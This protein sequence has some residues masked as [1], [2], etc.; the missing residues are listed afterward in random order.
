MPD[1]QEG[2][3]G[4][5][6]RKRISRAC[7]SCYSLRTK[8]NGE[9][10][11]QQCVKTSIPCTF[12]RAR[13][14]RGKAA[15]KEQDGHREPEPL[16]ARPPPVHAYRAGPSLQQHQHQQQQQQGFKQEQGPGI[17]P[18]FP[19]FNDGRT[20]TSDNGM[21][22]PSLQ[23]DQLDTLLSQSP[24]IP[25]DGLL[26][27]P[28]PPRE[29]S[30]MPP[31]NTSSFL[32]PT[33]T[34]MYA[35]E[36]LPSPM[37]GLSMFSQLAGTAAQ[38]NYM[39]NPQSHHADPLEYRRPGSVMGHRGGLPSMTGESPA[40]FKSASPQVH[41]PMHDRYR[42]TYHP[43]GSLPEG[44]R[45]PIFVAHLRALSFLPLHVISHLA[46]TYFDNSPY[47]LGYTLRQRDF[48]HPTTPRVTSPALVFA[49]L[50]VSAHT[51]ENAFFGQTPVMRAKIVQRLFELSVAA[52]RPLQHDEV[53]GGGLDDV[54]TYTQLGTIIM[55]SEFKGVSLRW[56]Y[57]A[58]TLAKELHLNREWT[59]HT[60]I[61]E[62]TREERRR[63]WWL[64]FMI[65]RHLCL[66]Y[67][68]PMVLMDVE[69]TN[70]L[71]PMDEQLW[72]SHEDIDG[73]GELNMSGD[74]QTPD[75]YL[76]QH[77]QQQH[78][79]GQFLKMLYEER[80]RGPRVFQ[81]Q[82]PGIFGFFLPLMSILGE[83]CTIFH[84]KHH[85]LLRFDDLAPQKARVREHLDAYKRSLERWNDPS[86]VP[87]PANIL[88]RAR[89]FSEGTF[90]AYALQLMHTMHI[91]L[92]CKFDPIDMMN[93][94]DG[95]ISSDEFIGA[96]THAVTA[97][98]AVSTILRIDPD[99]S[100]IPFFL[101][102]YLLQGSFL[103]FLIVDKLEQDADDAVIEACETY[104][105]AHESAITTLD[106]V[107]QRN[108]RRV[109]R[110][111]LNSIRYK[112]RS[113]DEEKEKR[114]ELLTLY[115]WSGDGRGLVV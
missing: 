106:T 9:N 73:P 59:E 36:T 53:G 32:P 81:V 20:P 55:A 79:H 108:F 22:L 25:P 56:L 78:Q 89:Q 94:A 102:I 85:I 2:P 31:S 97:A 37:T 99:L 50:C 43:P 115:R 82:G 88:T 60:A 12:D 61:S 87:A 91:L 41:L 45:Y 51:C 104:I 29:G 39:L 40:S 17:A 18:H 84:L 95:W 48:L 6:I 110:S 76:Q 52:L 64:L 67:N 13:K 4:G 111:T 58:W 27:S 114:R 11:C 57:G 65:D 90:V 14:K 24:G 100:Y 98:E 101:G 83:I 10:P 15:R 30:F 66:C 112:V 49:V 62:T 72:Q 33:S 113:T 3:A 21:R 71:H 69:C 80:A 7:D 19:Y 46:E 74:A 77:Q 8:C 107:Y 47:V 1:A 86:T 109:M 75:G 23:R 42:Q 70:L 105:R 54:M 26:P 5:P 35:T 96:T 93:D 92:C 63:A 44:L 68:K 38:T 34:G 28:H 103:L 16:A